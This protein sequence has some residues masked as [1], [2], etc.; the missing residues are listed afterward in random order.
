[1]PV[2]GSLC[3]LPSANCNS[4]SSSHV[5]QLDQVVKTIQPKMGSGVVADLAAIKHLVERLGVEE[6]KSIAELFG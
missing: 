1:M 3:R 4:G 2:F 5:A 6:V